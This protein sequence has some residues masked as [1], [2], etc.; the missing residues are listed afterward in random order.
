VK[1]PPRVQASL[2]D[3]ISRWRTFAIISHPGA[4]KTTLTERLLLFGGAFDSRVRS[5]PAATGGPAR[6]DWRAIERDRGIS[7]SAG[8]ITFEHDGLSFN[9]VENP[10]QTSGTLRDSSNS[11]RSS[12]GG[13]PRFP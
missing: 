3:A 9:Y 1:R 10:C 12:A 8:V 4:G 13:D 2:I 11:L 5:K 7:V 6:S